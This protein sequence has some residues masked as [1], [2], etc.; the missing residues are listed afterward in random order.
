[1][2]LLILA[3]AAGNDTNPAPEADL[4]WH[5]ESVA[6]EDGTAMWGPPPAGLVS[7]SILTPLTDAQ[8]HDTHYL[9]MEQ[10]VR[11]DDVTAIDC[12]GDV[13]VTWAIE[14]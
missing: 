8:Y 7:L 12:S 2:L 1:M 3:C 13:T 10:R 9:Q 11:A 14:R 6:C 4:E 5:T